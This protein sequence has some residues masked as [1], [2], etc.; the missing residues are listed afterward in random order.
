[1]TS[2][3]PSTAAASTPAAEAPLTRVFRNV[4]VHDGRTFLRGMRDV[5]V[6]GDTVTDITPCGRAIVPSGDRVEEIEAKGKTLTPGFIDCHVHF[7][8]EGA[9][10][11]T[12][13]TEP[14]SL[15]FYKSVAFME[16]TLRAGVTTARDAGGSDLGLKTALEQGYVRGPRTLTA[17]SI[18]S[19]TGGHGDG[20]MPSGAHSPMTTPHL[21]R[22]DG[23]A[24]GVDG[25]RRKAREILRAGADH[26]KICSTGGVLSAADDP[27]HSQ[28]T[29]EEIATIVE[30]CATQGT[31]VMSHAQGTNGIRNAVEAGVRSIEHG[32]YLDDETI[33]AMLEKGVWLVPTLQAPRAVIAGAEAGA[34]LPP[35]LVEKARMVA[36]V[37][38]ESVAK[39]HEA[40]VK[41][42]MGTDAG[43]GPH[44]ENLEEIELMA[45]VGMTVEQAL[46]AG[47][48]SA[49]ELIGLDGI[50]RIAPG[51]IADLVLHAG[52]LSDI[53]VADLRTGV[54]AVYQGGVQV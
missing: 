48:G 11:L 33:E 39:A 47:T 9:G 3:S 5:V 50:G 30:E 43:V 31:Y 52:D 25:V 44:G 34:A 38:V 35:A 8:T 16:R 51:A 13:F 23:V 54:E 1:M 26:I 20:F 19:Q 24:D 45:A 36:E 32:I 7:T 18:M 4:T 14:F 6:T 15:Q 53:G 42:A 10:S 29:R 2:T 28:F 17:V 46:A 41:I 37:H 21:G 27:R 40:G 12:A 49:A 22:P